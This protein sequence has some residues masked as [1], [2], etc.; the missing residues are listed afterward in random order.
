MLLRED[1]DLSEVSILTEATLAPI[2]SS[3]S[4]AGLCAVRDY[5][6]AG[7]LGPENLSISQDHS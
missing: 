3:L 4:E 7:A 5:L 2:A 6:A 1:V